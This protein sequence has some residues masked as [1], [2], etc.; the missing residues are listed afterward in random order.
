[1]ER[2]S[3]GSRPS[4]T[5]QRGSSQRRGGEERQLTGKGS[6]NLNFIDW[7][8]EF[9]AVLDHAHMLQE[10][11][12]SYQDCPYFDVPYQ[13]VR[14]MFEGGDDGDGLTP[15]EIASLPRHVGTV[16]DCSICMERSAEGLI[17][18]CGHIFHRQCVE[19]W[20]KNRTNCPNCRREVR[21]TP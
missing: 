11:G 12:L 19:R 20:L 16:K 6:Y 1:M 9:E 18:P 21:A 5:S 8:N 13:E 14:L 4:Q 15:E 3:R 7:D 10:R 17:L 2:K